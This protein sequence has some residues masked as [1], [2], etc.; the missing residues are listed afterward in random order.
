MNLARTLS[1]VEDRFT[2]GLSL[3]DQERLGARLADA[4]EE[5]DKATAE[6]WGMGVRCVLNAL[7][8]R[9]ICRICGCWEDEAC[10]GGCAWAEPDLCS[11]CADPVDERCVACLEPF[12]E[13]QLVLPDRDEGSIHAA[14]CGP[15]REA[16]VNAAGEPLGPDDPIPTGTPWS[17]HR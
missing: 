15:E 5:T 1:L 8:G 7:R 6:A 3:E 16:Y 4:H 9:H 10:D 14:C 17:A 2:D 12:K 13:G 11:A